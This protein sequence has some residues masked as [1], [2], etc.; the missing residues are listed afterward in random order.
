MSWGFFPLFFSFSRCQPLSKKKT[1]QYLKKL[2]AKKNR[3]S[4]SSSSPPTP[5]YSDWRSLAA[6]HAA[7]AFLTVP[8]S[9]SGRPRASLTVAGAA[10]AAAPAGAA[11]PVAFPRPPSPAAAA[12][13][14]TAS[15]V[16]AL[17]APY[18]ALAAVRRQLDVAQTL[19]A[20]VMPHSVMAGVVERRALGLAPAMFGG[21]G[22][23]GGLGGAGRSTT[24]GDPSS[25]NDA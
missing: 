4:S 10:R 8:A 17:L 11:A 19:L 18:L 23:G 22:G 7:T 24:G 3:P 25:D 9:V 13:A 21:G 12:A 15:A 2:K 6:S 20:D 14:A 1:H 16:A 5:P